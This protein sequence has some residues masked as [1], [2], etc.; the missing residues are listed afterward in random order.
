MGVTLPKLTTL[1]PVNHP[2]ANSTHGAMSA[3]CYSWGKE[4]INGLPILETSTSGSSLAPCCKSPNPAAQSGRKSQSNPKQ[5]CVPKKHQIEESEES[6]G[7]SSTTLDALRRASQIAPVPCVQM[8]ASTPLSI[9]E[10]A[11]VC[12][13]KS[14]SLC[15]LTA[16]YMK[17][18]RG[19][20]GEYQQRAKDACNPVYFTLVVHEDQE[21]KRREMLDDVDTLEDLSECGLKCL[22][23]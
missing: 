13:T 10:Q 1:S 9:V 16:N 22:H 3:T 5:F 19:I 11:Q 4:L 18:D 20:K 2:L 17:D 6:K 21:S 23:Q 14:S 15:G 7:C 8:A 12:S